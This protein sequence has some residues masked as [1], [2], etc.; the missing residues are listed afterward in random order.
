[1][2]KMLFLVGMLSLVSVSVSVAVAA[3]EVYKWTDAQ[4]RTRYT[5]IPPPS[6]VP[7]VTLSGKKS[8]QPGT[9]APAAGG[10]VA[11]S[12]E[13]P[14]KPAA[15][16]KPGSSPASP[17]TAADRELEEAKKK[18]ADAEE[19]KKK[20]Q[21]EENRKLKE[22]NCSVAKSNLIGLKQGGRIYSTNEKGERDYVSDADREKN[23]AQAEKDVA[24]WCTSQ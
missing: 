16:A 9:A 1:M 8:P 20:A 7:Y 12:A 5:D 17:K 2:K 13:P 24:E 10:E 18:I 11:P 23:I 19:K 3:T 14:V 6:N 15:P 22:K 21:E 4:G